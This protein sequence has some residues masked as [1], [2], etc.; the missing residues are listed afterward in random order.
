MFYYILSGRKD[1]NFDKTERNKHIV[2]DK[3]ERNKHVVSDKTER[4]RTSS[5]KV[6]S[7]RPLRLKI[8]HLIREIN[9]HFTH[10]LQ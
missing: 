7:F 4:N 3:T 1:T 6:D 2:F 9:H 5:K 10:A 8:Y